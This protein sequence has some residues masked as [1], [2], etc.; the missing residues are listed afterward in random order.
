MRDVRDIFAERVYMLPFGANYK[1]D[2]RFAITGGR[3]LACGGA[4]ES[5]TQDHVSIHCPAYSDLRVQYNLDTDL[6]LIH[7]Y[8][9]VISRR[10]EEKRKQD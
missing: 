10:D 4:E 5:E 8:R 6:G 1:H 9:E 3:C 2:R 7:F